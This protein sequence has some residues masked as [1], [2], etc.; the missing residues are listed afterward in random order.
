MWSETLQACTFAL[1]QSKTRRDVDGI[2]SQYLGKKSWLQSQ[3]MAMKAMGPEERKAYG[4]QLNQMK[5]DLTDLIDAAYLRVR[6][7]ELDALLVATSVDPTAPQRRMR[8]GSR[9]PVSLACARLTAILSDF[10]F[11]W[12]EGPELEDEHHNFTLLNV[13][14]SHPARAEQDTFYLESVGSLLRTH[15][16]PVQI[17]VLEHTA[18]PVR[19]MAPGRVYRSDMDAT[20]TPMFHQLEGLVVDQHVDMSDLKGTVIALLSSYFEDDSLRVRFRPGYFP[21]TEPSAEVDI[22]W[23]DRWLEVLGCGMVHPNVLR[24][25]N[26]SPEQ[27]RGYAFGVGMDRLAMLRYGIQDLRMMFENDHRMSACFSGAEL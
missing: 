4:A 6:Q 23:G 22:W 27:W 14:A 21:F 25:V 10:G 17:R 1:G 18:P 15:T 9:H 3:F 12:A 24:G 2:K 5:V 19:I 11:V 7:Q 20:H 8:L 26:I 16:S 13:P